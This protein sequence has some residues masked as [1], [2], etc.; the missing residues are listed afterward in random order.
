MRVPDGQSQNVI[1]P[2]IVTVRT[3]KWV[4]DS[5][6]SNRIVT[7]GSEQRSRLRKWFYFA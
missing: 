3:R 7:Q 5:E 6:L 2:S 1:R 4:Q